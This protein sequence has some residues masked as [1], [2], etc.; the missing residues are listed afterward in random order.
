M[1]QVKRRS[2]EAKA[3]ADRR[4]SMRVVKA[5][6]GRGSYCRKSKKSG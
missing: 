4:Y 1:K 3:L 5:K 6:K 2:Q